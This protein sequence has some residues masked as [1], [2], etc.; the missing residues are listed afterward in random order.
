MAASGLWA[1]DPAEF[2]EMRVRPVLAKNCFACHT[3][4][5]M[6]GLAMTS[7]EALLRGGQSGAAVVPG[8]PDDSLLMRAVRHDHDRLKMPPTGGRLPDAQLA[9]LAAWIKDGAVWPAPAAAPAKGITKEQ[10]EFWAF[11][12]VKPPAPNA[13]IDTLAKSTTAAADRHTLLRRVTYALTGLPPTAGEMKAFLA[14]RSPDAYAKVVD[15]L[16]G[17]PRYGEKWGR[18][19]LDVARYS[20]DKLHP[21]RDE[22]RPQAFRYRDWVIDSFNRDLPYKTFVQAHVAADLMGQPDLMPALGMYAMSPEFTDDRVD[23]TTRGFLG[24]TVACAQCH[25]HKFDPIP[26]RD[27]YALQGVF[28][29]T[30]E[31][32]FPLAPQDQVAL[33]DARKKAL[34]ERE[35]QLKEYLKAQADQLADILANRAAEYLAA[36]RGQRPVEGLDAEVLEKWKKYVERPKKEHDLLAAQ[37]GPAQF[38]ELLLAVNREKKEID[39]KNLIT[40][41]GS[42]KRG[43]LSDANLASLERNRY[44]LWR[45]FF[46]DKGVL[47][48]GEGKIDRFLSGPFKEHLAV[49]RQRVDAAK[50]ALPSEYPYLYTIKDKSECKNQRVQ[51]RGN[52]QNL[53]DE[54]PRGFLTILHD[55]APKPFTK[56]AGRLELAE[57]LTS[58]RNPLTARVMVN[59][60]WQWH[61]GEGLVKTASNFGQLG[62]RPSNAALLDYL[63]SRFVEQG[64]SVKKLQR[65]ILL[66]RYYQAARGEPRRLD[67][68]G[69]RDA[70]LAV[71]G[72]LDEKRGGVAEPLNEKNKRRTVYGF[73]SRRRLDPYLA[74]F[75]FPNPM[76]TSEGRVETDVPLQRLFLLN[77]PLVLEA[78]ET[79]AKTLPEG[80]AETRIDALYWRLLQ[81]A[82]TPV[83]RKLGASFVAA[84]G[85]TWPMYVQTLMAS[86]EFLA[87]N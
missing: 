48:F 61:F 26:T 3:Q 52:P 32:K 84:P 7:R 63:A 30:E 53:G 56:G 47:Y 85:N 4:S 24:L 71:S 15:R 82:A 20:D 58:D 65:E 40:L 54:V 41:G 68:E 67:A 57:A 38:Q 28:A 12:P 36:A 44:F 22:P 62:E 10:R 78:A 39:E 11:Q 37:T 42:K 83:E 1:A 73:V 79:L 27:Y 55:A 80:K 45:D 8:Q 18:H 14:D 77:S 17:S 2:F 29:N 19:W 23:V 31:S 51:I 35:E 21:E 74:L 16:L 50:K 5:K 6:G 76:A 34:D 72:L 69:V 25:D 81:R 86:H 33:Y 64:W 49:L 9:D 13:S 59:R 46:G 70:I 43:D 66:S 60:I 87:V 75:D